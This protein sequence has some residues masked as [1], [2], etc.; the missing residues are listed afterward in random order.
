MTA[1]AV[2]VIGMHRSG[3]SVV[4]RAVKEYGFDL[5]DNL[6]P[7]AHDNVK[8]FWEDLDVVDLN[9]RML[10]SNLGSWDRLSLFDAKAFPPERLE[11]YCVSAEKLLRRKFA[12]ISRFAV[13]DP[14]I[15]LTLP[16]W[17]EAFSRTGIESQCILCLR[18]PNSVAM[19]LQA[20]NA[21]PAKKALMLWLNHVYSVLLNCRSPLLVVG[22]ESMLSSPQHHLGRI[23]RFLGVSDRQR[24]SG[25]TDFSDFADQFLDKSLDHN[26]LQHDGTSG[27]LQL[28]DRLYQVLSGFEDSPP[29]SRVS[30]VQLLADLLLDDGLITELNVARAADLKV[31]GRNAALQQLNSAFIEYFRQMTPSLQAFDDNSIET[32][33][34]AENLHHELNAL[35]ED[36]ARVDADRQR[37]DIERI[38]L[39]DENNSL[40]SDKKRLEGELAASKDE[41]NDSTGRRFELERKLEQLREEFSQ[42]REDL[43]AATAEVEELRAIRDSRIWRM[44]APLRRVVGAIYRFQGATFV[45]Q[46]RKLSLQPLQHLKQI[47]EFAWESV[48][49]DPQFQLVNCRYPIQPGTY[50][51]KMFVREGAESLN[52]CLYLDYGSGYREE[53]Y[54]VLSLIGRTAK[55]LLTITDPVYQIRFDPCDKAAKFTISTIRWRPVSKPELLLRLLRHVIRKNRMRG[56]S[57]WEVLRSG[58]QKATQEGWSN[59]WRNTGFYFKGGGQSISNVLSYEKWIAEF[60]QP[61]LALK[62]GGCSDF[63]HLPVIV[64]DSSG[65]ALKSSQTLDNLLCQQTTV[66]P[67]LL[68]S[69]CEM[70]GLKTN[71]DGIHVYQDPETIVDAMSALAGS[72][73]YSHIAVI[74]AGNAPDAYFLRAMSTAIAANPDARLIYTDSDQLVNGL[75]RRLPEF[76]PEWSPDYQLAAH[77]IG[78]AFVVRSDVLVQVTPYWLNH[79]SNSLYALLAMIADLLDT[80][81]TLRIPEILWHKTR[82]TALAADITAVRPILS[83]TGIARTAAVEEAN[84]PR[85][86]RLRYPI[87]KTQPRV[88]IIIPTRDQCNLLKSCIDSILT[89]TSYGNYIVTI[90]DN[91]STEREALVYLD[92]LRKNPRFKVLSYPH[93]FNYSAINN[94]AVGQSDAEL[95]VLMNNDIEVISPHWLQEMVSCAIRENA[96]C[97]G[98]KLYYPDGRIQHAGVVLGIHGVAGHVFRLSERDAV[99]YL[100]RLRHVQNYSVV[101]GACLALRREIYQ[102]VGGLNDRDL[103][104]AFNDIDLCLKVQDAGFRNV[105]TPYAELYHHESAT[106]G[107]YDDRKKVSGLRREAAYIAQRW[108]ALLVD[109]PAYNPNLSLAGT[110][111]EL[112]TRYLGGVVTGRMDTAGGIGEHPYRTESNI[113]RVNKVLALSQV[114]SLLKCKYK[115]GLSIVILTLEKLELI[116][117][118]LESLVA[119]KGVLEA[120][121]G[122]ELQIIVGDT[123]SV[124][125]K[126]HEL[127]QRLDPDITVIRDMKYHFSRCNNQLFKD[128]VK[129]DAVLFL[130]NDIVFSNPVN[131]LLEMYRLLNSSE[132]IAVVGTYLLYP[133]KRL[134]H[135]G[136]AMFTDGEL[137]GLCYHPGH[138]REFRLPEYGRVVDMPA[139]TGACLMMDSTLFSGCDYFD[140]SYEAE[141]Q[142][143]DLCIKSR[144]AGYTVK[145]I[146]CGEVIHYENATRPKGDANQHD[147]SRFIR[148]WKTY[149]EVT[150]V[151]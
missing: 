18:H 102:Q 151:G 108:G 144:R 106:R 32:V 92:E 30:Q 52:P 42:V 90:I 128:C 54:L 150:G 58:W 17:L 132:E 46:H 66:G 1:S 85:G 130:N 60:E 23:A 135:G 141:A 143:V 34:V 64:F 148:K 76:K 114:R 4:A 50:L 139:V 13:K 43:Q 47:S 10:D 56:L 133:N 138:N 21:M 86:Y 82:D 93:P 74:G 95:V 115:P 68:Y 48:D 120:E 110:E 65:D 14:R 142:D 121:H 119:A 149:Q 101:T 91:G 75:H 69:T 100:D 26:K 77:Y 123:G 104:V 126:V 145:M 62:Y 5:G 29:L 140:E 105:W 116:K 71:H 79:G 8:G 36:R 89:K 127:Y 39:L 122:I 51:I 78:D 53:D 125:N 41:V 88:D 15:S 118:L 38:K 131:S 16:V 63:T 22:Y 6:V 99:G 45:L 98:A 61:H 72:G 124:D 81:N 27:W 59:V 117:P 84:T 67:V 35:R 146:S 103:E 33:I 37:I 96:G 7:P 73:S 97:V 9:E 70:H 80:G 31:H 137:K 44:T 136:V 19:S 20:R 113:V 107:D 3:T 57:L 87:P 12:G 28:V 112:S 147:R 24:T 134:Q 129:Y 11:H 25:A 55:A 2:L 94:F 83:G 111:F 109:D 49:H 40:V